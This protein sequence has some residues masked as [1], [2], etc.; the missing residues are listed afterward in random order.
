[1]KTLLAPNGK[2]SNLNEKQ[3]KLVRT[4]AFKKWFGDWEND[5]ENSS[6]VV[7]ENG[8]PKVVTHSTSNQDSEG[9]KYNYP[10]FKIFDGNRVFNTP[11]SS[12]IPIWFSYEGNYVIHETIVNMPFFLNIKRLFLFSN[13]KHLKQLKNYMIKN[14]NNYDVDLEYNYDN[15]WEAIEN[16]NLPAFIKEMG[17]DGYKTN[18]E[19]AIAIFE[20]KQGKLADGS[21]TIFDANNDDIRYEN[22]GLIAPNGKPSNLTPEQYKL[23]RTSKFKNWFGNWETKRFRLN[24]KSLN[25]IY[26]FDT[27]SLDENGEPKIWYRGSYD[28][29]NEFNTKNIYLGSKKSYVKQYGNLVKEFFVFSEKTIFIDNEKIERKHLGIS[30]E[31]LAEYLNEQNKISLT[32]KYYQKLKKIFKNQ[33]ENEYLAVW[34]YFTE[35]LNEEVLN[36]FKDW[37]RENGFDCI[38]YWETGKKNN[39]GKYPVGLICLYFGDEIKLADGT[40]TEFD[41]YEVDIRYKNGG[42]TISQTPAPKNE[43]IYGSNTNKPNSSKSVTSAKQINFDEKTI[44]SIKNKIDKHNEENPDKLITLSSA[45]AVVRRGMGAYSSSHRP[46]IK[47][48]KPNSRVAW[49]LARLNAFIYKI[50]NGV[51]KSGKYTQDDDLIKELNIKYNIG[52][53]VSD[54][55]FNNIKNDKTNYLDILKDI[56]N[57]FNIKL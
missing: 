16:E 43:R 50:I 47:G 29:Y 18:S 49:G 56:W 37:F 3:Y 38:Q 48:G 15:N 9:N 28:D 24:H 14:Y 25:D 1:M 33:T 40:N 44:K 23:V 52:G 31:Y 46:T 10:P 30:F 5:P 34:E 6:K 57:N 20:S 8:E 39:F 7:D 22:G 2:P 55:S 45:K 21:N 53:D 36:L 32:G 4:P 41:S 54:A 51:S 17:Y 19:K 42:R 11:N 26:V 35:L 27:I 13:Q 12:V